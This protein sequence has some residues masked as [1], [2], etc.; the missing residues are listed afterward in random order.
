[1]AKTKRQPDIETIIE[2]AVNAGLKAGRREAEDIYKATEKRLYALPVLEKRIKDNQQRLV[3]LQTQGS[4]RRSKDIRRLS[5]PGMRLSPDEILEVLIA[6][7][8]AAIA[9][10]EYEVE[11][12]KKAL[13]NIKDDPYYLTVEGRYFEQISDDEIAKKIHCD[14]TTVWRQRKRLVQTIAVWLYGADAV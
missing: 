10:D 11:T 4:P 5:R 6:D 9:K 7:V 2:K 14:T 1:M 8:E 13:E 12:I 3:E